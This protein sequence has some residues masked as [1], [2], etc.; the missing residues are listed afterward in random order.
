[1]LLGTTCTL[2]V[3]KL[4]AGARLRPAPLSS[5]WC[6]CT[7]VTPLVP[8]SRCSVSVLY[9]FSLYSACL[10]LLL[11]W[12][13]M[14]SSHSSC[15][16]L[17]PA[18]G[19]VPWTLMWSILMVLIQPAASG[20]QLH[21]GPDKSHVKE[22][23]QEEWYHTCVLLLLLTSLH[24]V[25][26]LTNSFSSRAKITLQHSQLHFLCISEA[27]FPLVRNPAKAS[28][29]GQMTWVSIYWPPAPISWDTNTALVNML[30]FILTCCLIFQ[31]THTCHLPQHGAV[32][33]ETLW[34]HLLLRLG[35]SPANKFKNIESHYLTAV[36]QTKITM[37]LAQATGQRAVWVHVM[38]SLLAVVCMCLSVQS[39][40]KG[41]IDFR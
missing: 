33:P 32:K 29:L 5:D 19:G 3:N 18:T 30:I 11:Q 1:M 35:R 31:S 12:S 39:N 38:T 24:E 26:S 34:L 36:P 2:V 7:F 23:M 9:W 14:C 41:T 15:S 16:V 27:A 8:S 22:I 4:I 13:L 20:L 40:Q 21:L 25:L 6:F 17:K 10:T 37:T 28:V